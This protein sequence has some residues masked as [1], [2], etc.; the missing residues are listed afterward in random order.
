MNTNFFPFKDNEKEKI[1][2]K[3]NYKKA[4]I[5]SYKELS[6]EDFVEPF[7]FNKEE[8]TEKEKL[9]PKK[10]RLFN[11]VEADDKNKNLK[12]FDGV[13][14]NSYININNNDSNNN[15]NN[16]YLNRKFSNIIFNRLNK[17]NLTSEQNYNESVVNKFYFC[18]KINFVNTYKK[19]KRKKSTITKKSESFIK[20]FLLN[21]TI[22]ETNH[23]KNMN[24]YQSSSKNL[25]DEKDKNIS[26]PKELLNSK[27]KDLFNETVKDFKR[28]DDLKLAYTFHNINIKNKNEKLKH[29]RN[30]NERIFSEINNKK[31]I[32]QIKKDDSLNNPK[33]I[34]HKEKHNYI[35]YKIKK[36][37]NKY[38]KNKIHSENSGVKKQEKKQILKNPINKKNMRNKNAD[39]FL[40]IKK[41]DDSIEKDLKKTESKF[42]SNQTFFPKGLNHYPFYNSKENNKYKIKKNKSTF[43]FRN[44]KRNKNDFPLFNIMN[45]NPKEKENNFTK[46]IHYYNDALCTICHP[47]PNNDSNKFNITQKTRTY[48]I[49][50][51]DL[52]LNSYIN[53]NKGENKYKLKKNNSKKNIENKKEYNRIILKE[54]S[55]SFQNKKEPV[56]LKKAIK[57]SYDEIIL[58]KYE[59]EFIAV[60]E[61]FK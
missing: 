17:L 8:F 20:D 47:S 27:F 39:I 23:I 49:T 35:F 51:N 22:S 11:F 42:K 19:K 36:G 33:Y 48:S 29:S 7:H 61:Y 41:W 44:L 24:I 12:I 53:Q 54:I 50:K 9:I 52:Q 37:K 3:E 16:H 4:K 30:N 43:N 6:K 55:N 25:E 10:N 38:N 28:K 60:N 40:P 45:S 13:K 1:K 14:F 34:P 15:R 59:S 26:K 18:T 32:S 46:Y 2:N 57:P 58:R 56:I 31:N 5:I 21:K